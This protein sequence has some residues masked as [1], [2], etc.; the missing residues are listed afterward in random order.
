MFAGITEAMGRMYSHI[1]GLIQTK[2]FTTTGVLILILIHI[3]ACRG[4]NI[5]QAIPADLHCEY[6]VTVHPV[7]PVGICYRHLILAFL[8]ETILF[9]EILRFQQVHPFGANDSLSVTTPISK[10]PAISAGPLFFE[11]TKLLAN[12]R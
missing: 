11:S 7:I 4:Q 2:A 10:G 5:F 12:Y 8:L 6:Q 1:T 3:Q 9:Q